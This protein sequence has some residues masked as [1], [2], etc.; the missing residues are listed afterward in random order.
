MTGCNFGK[1]VRN[2]FGAR[3]IVQRCQVHKLR[4]FQALNWS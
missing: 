4:K 1:A 3:A 2:V